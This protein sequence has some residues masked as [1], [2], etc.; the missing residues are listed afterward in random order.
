MDPRWKRTVTVMLVGL[1]LAVPVG[2]I[3]HPV[4]ADS[5]DV[6]AA[7][8]ALDAA[9]KAQEQAESDYKAL[10]AH[11]DAVKRMQL[12]DMEKVLVKGADQTG[13]VVK[14]LLETNRQLIGALDAVLKM[15]S[16]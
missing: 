9:R 7:R 12:D 8:A 1:L 16:K 6:Q 10:A 4:A 13:A 14:T 2:L 3:P 15:Q 11:L 5:P